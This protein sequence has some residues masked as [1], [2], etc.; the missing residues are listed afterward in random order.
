MKF[1]FQQIKS[2]H[3]RLLLIFII[4]LAVFLR[5]FHIH[6]LS[7]FIADQAIMSTQTLEII[8]GHLTLLGPRA[9]IAPVYFGPIVFYLMT[10]FYILSRGYPLAGTIFQITLQI[11][12]I[13]FVFLIGKKVMNE[14]TGLIAAFLFSISALFVQYSRASFNTTTALSFSTFII[15]IFLSILDNYKSWKVLL[16]GILLGFLIQMN[17]ITVSLFTAIIIFPFLFHRKLLT[18]QY[19]VFL[20]G[21]FVVGFSPY[22]FFELRHNFFNTH[23]MLQYLFSSNGS[24][25]K[26]VLFF[27]HDFPIIT[28]QVF[29]GSADFW[30]GT[31]TLFLMA[32]GSGII[33]IN[34]NT[35]RSFN[36]LLFLVAN[37]V[38]ISLFYGR[39]LESI[40]VITLHTALL[41]IFATMIVFFFK[42]RLSILLLLTLI[43]FLNAPYWNLQKSMNDLQDGLIMSDF[44]KAALIIQH[45]NP[46]PNSNVAMDAQRDN[47]AMPLRYF[48]FLYNIPVLNYDNYSKANTLYFIERKTKNLT[49]SNIWEYTSFGPSKVIHTWNINDEYVLYKLKKTPTT[50]HPN[51]T[52]EP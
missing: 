2:R 28:S 47:R 4:I 24:T 27:L 14:Q 44:Q 45:D 7:V 37:V 38:C 50:L 10:P 51:R 13:P 34:K 42:N 16:M 23:A 22:I 43:L 25:K 46:S 30:L 41:V 29:Y 9:S 52:T 40:Y 8:R 6:Q 33:L 26:S 49:E 31:I 1:I 18:I 12:A 11:I 20:L 19:Y 36:F 39:H 48:L 35:N 15:Y 3:N 17:F 21:G 5:T 32:L